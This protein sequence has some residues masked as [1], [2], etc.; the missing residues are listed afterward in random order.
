MRMK[1]RPSRK[2]S[3][4]LAGLG[5]RRSAVLQ[6]PIAGVSHAGESLLVIAT[7][8]YF[9]A[10]ACFAYAWLGQEECSSAPMKAHR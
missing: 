10:L 8:C 4:D 6:V 2:L 1:G 7:P 9:V 5:K 3:A